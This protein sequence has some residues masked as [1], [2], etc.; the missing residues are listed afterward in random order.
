MHN[1][2]IVI[3]GNGI[4]SKC[5]VFELNKLG[6]DNITVI[7]SDSYAP[8]CSTRTTAINCLRGTE[9]G[10]SEL[11]DK[12][13]DSFEIFEDFYR[14]YKPLGISETF[15]MHTTPVA[16][17]E[18]IA[19]WKRRYKKYD[20]G[21]E[22]SLF[23]NSLNTD[24][25]YI[26]NKAYIISPEIY[27]NWFDS[28]N[29][30]TLIEEKVDKITD[31]HIV[32]SKGQTVIADELIICTS[33]MSQDFSKLVE[34]EK[35]KHRLLHSKPVAGSYLKFNIEDFNS[36]ELDL[37]TTYCFRVD[38]V[39][40]IIRPD[41]KDVL[42]GSTSTNNSIDMNGDKEGMLKQYDK[43]SRY[44]E[45]VVKLP[46]FD[47]SEII[48]GIRHKGQKRTPYWGEIAKNKYAVWGLYKNAFTFSNMAAK[49]LVRL[50]QK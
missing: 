37:N 41:S 42:I 45:G 11:G 47:K 20:K 39:H 19:K 16:P 25:F 50:I 33:Y 32:T 48:T 21:C 2:H 12:I 18:L 28:H 24:L 38:E 35:L 31:M 17:D 9:R 49:E 44:L 3:I 27:F 1:K 29:K 6:F 13:I 46:H 30:F 4:A 5:V 8:M 36:N 14:N 34:D 23:K 40:L 43:L 26:E 7:A 22:F 15:E 10:N